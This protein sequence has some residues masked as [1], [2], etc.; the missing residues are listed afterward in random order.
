MKEE[1]FVAAAQCTK[2]KEEPAVKDLHK[3]DSAQCNVVTHSENMSNAGSADM[4]CEKW[5]SGTGTAIETQ[6]SPPTRTQ[7]KSSASKPFTD[8]QTE[9]HENEDD[10]ELSR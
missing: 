9:K 2:E 7:D 4:A 10:A 1:S 5:D 8:S 6:A 3:T